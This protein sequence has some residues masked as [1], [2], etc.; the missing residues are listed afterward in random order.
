[1]AERN[2]QQLTSF[3]TLDVH[4][5]ASFKQA[6][7]KENNKLKNLYII[8]YFQ[9]T[10]R[11]DK[12]EFLWGNVAPANLHRLHRTMIGNSVYSRRMEHSACKLK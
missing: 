12:L 6:L 5:A 1:M 11:H 4:I 9:Y 10:S 7:I 8:N 2:E 3:S